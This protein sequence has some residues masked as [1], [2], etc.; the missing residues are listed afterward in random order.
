MIGDANKMLRAI[1]STLGLAIALYAISLPLLTPDDAQADTEQALLDQK[2]QWQDR[3]RSLLRDAAHFEQS[4]KK[5]RENYAR[6]RRRNYP[7]GGARQLFILEADEAEKK[8][9]IVK[10][11]IA[12][13]I[14]DARRNAIPTNWR[15]E[16]EDE[17]VTLASPAN[18][19]EDDGD[20]EDDRAG[21]NPL[22][23]DD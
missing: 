19:S 16:V 10:D 4:A 2:A 20:G 8:L 23:F 13:L 6:A 15:Y 21:R 7:R 17:P 3:Y 14:V 11:E 5:S 1:V 22:Y 12:Q 18:A 9:V